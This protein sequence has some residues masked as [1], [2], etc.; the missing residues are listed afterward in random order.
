METVREVFV[1]R[2]GVGTSVL[3][4]PKP[5]DWPRWAVRRGYLVPRMLNFAIPSRDR[6]ISVNP[7]GLTL[8]GGVGGTTRGRS[9]RWK[10]LAWGV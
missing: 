2:V 10:G 6:K 1:G 8:R 3:D 7:G 9:L 4:C 5:D